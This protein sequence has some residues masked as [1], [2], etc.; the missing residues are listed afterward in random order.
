MQLLSVSEV[1]R[2]LGANPKDVSDLFYR[3]RLIPDGYLEII[4]MALKR[5]GRPVG[6]GRRN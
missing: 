6:T 3:R 2:R 1:A 4:E 5:A